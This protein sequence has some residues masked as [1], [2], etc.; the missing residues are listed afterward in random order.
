MAD[1][2]DLLWRS[3]LLLWNGNNEKMNVELIENLFGGIIFLN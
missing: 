2:E 1:C 3:N